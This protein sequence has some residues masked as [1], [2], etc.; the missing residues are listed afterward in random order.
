M[1]GITRKAKGTGTMNSK[2]GRI[3]VALAG[4]VALAIAVAGGISCV[5][6]ARMKAD[7]AMVKADAACRIADNGFAISVA[8]QGTILECKTE[9]RASDDKRKINQG[10]IMRELDL[11]QARQMDLVLEVRKI[12]HA[13]GHTSPVR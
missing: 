11:M 13:H 4:I 10:S 6:A 5:T 9:I 7:A 3:S 8:N 1:V 2:T 12:N